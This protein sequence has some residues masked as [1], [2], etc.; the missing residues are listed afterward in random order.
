MSPA[1]FT[2]AVSAP[3]ESRFVDIDGTPIHYLGW[4]LADT[5]K[6]GLLFAHGFRAHA[7]WWSFVA[8]FFM[9]RFR[10][11]ALDFSGMGD[12]GARDAYE[13]TTFARDIVGVLEHAGL[14]RA[15]LIGH[16]FGGGRVART[17]A[18]YPE[19]V[20][21]AVIIDSFVRIPDI[22]QRLPPPLELRPKKIYPTFEAARARFRLVP[23]QNAAAPYVID[24]IAE[25][26]L[27]QVEGGWTWKFDENFLP[28]SVHEDAEATARMLASISC[29]VTYLYGDLSIVVTRP[30]AHAIVQ[31]LQ[32]GRGPIALPQ[33]HHHVM[34]DQ[35]LSLVAALRGVLY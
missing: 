7:R 8:P 13:A 6:P 4:N 19:I 16:S 9:S 22:Q 27:K 3:H 1:W 14:G 32:H 18:D 11:V 15:T 23:E 20:E 10:I 12:S 26:S 31:R 35:P 33:A 24:F 17:C 5:E 25:H 34:L 29:P 30:L 21:R 28:R 2:R